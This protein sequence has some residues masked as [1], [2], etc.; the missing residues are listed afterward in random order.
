MQGAPVLSLIRELDPAC[1][2]KE[3]TCHNQMSMCC[4]YKISQKTLYATLEIED[5]TCGN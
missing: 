2:N 5:A 1:H 3:F 4:S